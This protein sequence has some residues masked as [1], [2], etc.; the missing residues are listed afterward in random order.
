VTAPSLAL[1]I[2]DSNAVSPNTGKTRKRP[3]DDFIFDVFAE[4]DDEAATADK[5]AV[6]LWKRS[7]RGD[8]VIKRHH[9]MLQ[10]RR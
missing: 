7:C 4:S 5:T 10:C 2:A 8:V 6:G 9:H 1:A 3:L